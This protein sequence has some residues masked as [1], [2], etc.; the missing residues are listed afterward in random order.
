MAGGGGAPQP[1]PKS[2][3]AA[4]KSAEVG[5]RYLGWMMDNSEQPRAWATEDRAR[6]GE[7]FRPLEDRLVDTAANWDTPLRRMDRANAAEADVATGMAAA[8]GATA[9]TLAAQGVMPGSGRAAGAADTL[10]LQEG[11]ARAGARN[12]AARQVEAEGE[13]KM[14]A[15][16]NLGR[17]MAINPATSLQMASGMVAQ[18][19]QGA[20][21]GYNQQASLLGRQHDQQMQAWQ[22]D[23]ASSGALWGGIGQLAGLAFFSSKEAKTDKRPPSRSMLGAVRKM[24]VQEWNYKKGMGD[25]ARHV[26]PYAEDFQRA[27]GKGD[28][29]TIPVVDA[30]GAVMGAVQEL[31]KKVAG[32]ARRMPRQQAA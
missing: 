9:R 28:G 22:A 1:D 8:R 25:D 3:E 16:V 26:G 2:G 27:T 24:P 29:R 14:G 15:A 20:M 23:Q 13:A 19:N 7:V 5:E 11:L 21:T 31:D 4:L 32:L 6:W 17:G 10:T 12:I 18:G 30:V